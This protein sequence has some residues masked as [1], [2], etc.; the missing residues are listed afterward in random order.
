DTV[1]F[2]V[3]GLDAG[4]TATVTFADGNGHTVA[5]GVSGDQS[6]YVADLSTLADGP[7]ASTLTIVPVPGEPS[8][9]FSGN[10]VLLDQDLGE[11]AALTLTISGDTSAP[12]VKPTIGF[13][14]A[15]LEPED[16]GRVIFTDGDGASVTVPVTGGQTTYQATL[17]SLANGAITSALVVDPDP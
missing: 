9:N 1:A 3:S 17:S 7:I 11:Q 5:V 6:G 13:T 16:T 8:F 4:E 12:L 10:S 15:G 14:I 2:T